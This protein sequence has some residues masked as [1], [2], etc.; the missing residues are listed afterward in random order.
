MPKSK[1]SKANWTVTK[2][3]KGA[4]G[5]LYV[6]RDSKTGR[7][8]WRGLA[9]RDQPT[10]EALL[11]ASSEPSEPSEPSPRKVNIVENAKPGIEKLPDKGSKHSEGSEMLYEEGEL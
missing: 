3:R 5:E 9:R 11:P 8:V 2:S 1:T 6:L 7:N 10:Q 4:S